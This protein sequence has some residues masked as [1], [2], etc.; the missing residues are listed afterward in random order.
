MSLHPGIINI[1]VI[2]TDETVTS[3]T[4]LAN[5]FSFNLPANGTI[6]WEVVGVF[7]LGAAGGFK[8]LPHNAGTSSFYIAQFEIEDVTTPTNYQQAVTTETAFANAA[9]V[10]SNYSLRAYGTVKQGAA[11]GAFSFQFAQNSSNA[12]PITMKAGTIIRVHTI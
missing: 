6:Y 12:T 2:T 8:F 9:A 7:T 1:D 11:A 3:S 10:A 4:T 5:L